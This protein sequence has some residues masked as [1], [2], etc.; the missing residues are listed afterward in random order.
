MFPVRYWILILTL[1]A[2][3]MLTCVM[4]ALKYC[5]PMMVHSPSNYCNP[6]KPWCDFSKEEKLS[7]HISPIVLN[8]SCSNTSFTN[9]GILKYYFKIFFT[10]LIL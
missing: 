3:S 7:H 10:V 6:H 8:V 9:F 4:E 1:L 5:I 2:N